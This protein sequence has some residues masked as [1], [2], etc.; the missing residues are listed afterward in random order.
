MPVE[1]KD[2]T[3]A[4]KRCSTNAAVRKMDLSLLI[5]LRGSAHDCNIRAES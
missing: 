4:L 2:P 5:A 1:W 3:A